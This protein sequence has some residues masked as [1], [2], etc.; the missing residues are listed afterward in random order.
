MEKPFDDM[1]RRILQAATELFVEKG[2]A[3]TNMSDIAARAG[4]NRPSLHYYFRTKDRLFQ[5]AF[6]NILGELAPRIKDILQQSDIPVAGRVEQ[7]VDAYY[8]IFRTTPS[9][10]L[11]ILREMQ[12]DFG[13]VVRS[14]QELGFAQYFLIVGRCLE[15]EMEDGHIRRVP[16]RFLFLNFYSL[17]MFPFLAHNLCVNILLTPE[18][19]YSD[20]LEHWK[21]YI[22][23]QICHLLSPQE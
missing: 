15:R 1:E 6:G 5:V 11:F 12:R 23:E 9:L 8:H 14:V 3:E 7:V 18:E 22:V 2:Y 19:S 21:P 20:F 10:P 17:L 4:I 16:L 13:F